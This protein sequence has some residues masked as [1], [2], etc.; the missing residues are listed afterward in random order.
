[1]RRHGPRLGRWLVLAGALAMR[2]EV[3]RGADPTRQALTRAKRS[4]EVRARRGSPLRLGWNVDGSIA[5]GTNVDD[6][7]D[8]DDVGVPPHLHARVLILGPKGRG[9]L[10]IVGRDA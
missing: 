10:T 6:V 7:D 4:E 9:E 8:V 5:M 3:I 2:P 1:M